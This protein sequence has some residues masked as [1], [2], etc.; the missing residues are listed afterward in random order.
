MNRLSVTVFGRTLCIAFTGCTDGF[1]KYPDD[2][3][4]RAQEQILLIYRYVP[5]NWES[6]SVQQK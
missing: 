1:V 5:L 3:P 4:I 2:Q 6:L